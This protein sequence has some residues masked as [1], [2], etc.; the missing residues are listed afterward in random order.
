M[1]DPLDQNKDII[2]TGRDKTSL[3]SVAGAQHA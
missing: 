3:I 2:D 1:N